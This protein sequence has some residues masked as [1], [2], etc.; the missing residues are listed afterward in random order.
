M[1]MLGRCNCMIRYGEDG[2]WMPAIHDGRGG[3]T[4]PRGLAITIPSKWRSTTPGQIRSELTSLGQT[5]IEAGGMTVL[6]TPGR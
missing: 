3:F 2:D 5:M 1:D 4:D 6:E